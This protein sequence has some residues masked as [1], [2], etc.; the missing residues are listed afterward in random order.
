MPH[1]LEIELENLAASGYAI[2]SPPERTYNCIA[3]AAGE[4]HRVWWPVAFS[5]WP[6]GVPRELTVQSFIM[7]FET[8]NYVP[9]Q[10]GSLEPGF[11]KVAIYANEE[12]IPRHAAR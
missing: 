3:F 7:V 8:L 6:D 5:Y 12:G 11:E 9:C 10:D 4:T 2:T 1:R